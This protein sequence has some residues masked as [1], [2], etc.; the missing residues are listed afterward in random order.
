MTLGENFDALSMDGGKNLLLA[1]NQ[2]S[3]GLDVMNGG[4][5]VCI[6]IHQPLRSRCHLSATSGRS[7]PSSQM[8]HPYTSTTRFTTVSSNGYKHIKCVVSLSDKAVTNGP[9]VHQDSLLGR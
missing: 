8:V 1:M 2:S 4:G 7:A 3:R 6:Y 9:V 5:W